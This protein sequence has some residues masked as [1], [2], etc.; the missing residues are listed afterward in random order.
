MQAIYLH[1]IYIHIYNITYKCR[2]LEK[3]LKVPFDFDY[4]W[5]P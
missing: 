4:V 5:Y 3:P 2:A 1:A